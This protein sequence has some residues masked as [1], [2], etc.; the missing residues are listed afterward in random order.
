MDLTCII[1]ELLRPGLQNV[2]C[3]KLLIKQFMALRD[4]LGNIS[5]ASVFPEDFHYLTLIHSIK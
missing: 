2:L 5:R 1:F 3:M 4:V